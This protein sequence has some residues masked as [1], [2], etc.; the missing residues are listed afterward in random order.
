MKNRLPVA[1]PEDAEFRK[2]NSAIGMV[3]QEGKLTFLDR[4]IF[5]ATVYH[6]QQIR[7]LGVNAPVAD[8]I[9]DQYYWVPLSHLV[10][11]AAFN[12]RDTET[13][14]QSV[15]NLQ[16]IKVKARSETDWISERLLGAVRLHKEGRGGRVW[17]GFRY[18][19]TVEQQVM[20]PLQYT[21]VNLYFQ[22][23]LRTGPGLALYEMARR[24]ATNPSH[25]SFKERW[26]WWHNYLTGQAVT[27]EPLNIEYKYFKRNVLNP[28]ILE[29]N[30]V[31]NV[32]VELIEI[33][34]GRRVE[35]LQFSASLKPQNQL[36]LPPEP[37]VDGE[38]IFNLQKLGL[39]EIDARNYCATEDHGLL[40]RTIQLIRDRL[41]STKLD[42]VGS[43][44]AYFR[45]LMRARAAD[46]S[47][48]PLKE[49]SRRTTGPVVI[50]QEPAQ[51]QMD[52][53]R[54]AARDAAWAKFQSSP[55][56]ERRR[57]VDSFLPSLKGPSLQAFRKQGIEANLVRHAFV[58][59]L[60]DRVLSA[61]I[62]TPSM[63]EK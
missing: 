52:D 44:P 38:L 54:R 43:V 47:Q 60:T 15:D 31:T 32:Q 23:M 59:W 6:A 7:R 50:E 24:Y 16:S 29:V 18:D 61:A 5:N 33:K 35:A 19:P 42:P 14:M 36:E 41:A 20:D 57:L 30:T 63:T 1:I 40:K 45:K 8:A 25:L 55:E 56:E 10:K 21:V 11:D 48:Q 27:D 39:S 28:A 9:S 46:G 37:I 51:K 49:V 2:S 3:V 17:L 26:E 12:S 62:P 13:F 4:K 53:A 22:A 34:A 58:G